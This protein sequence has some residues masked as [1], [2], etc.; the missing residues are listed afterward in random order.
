MVVQRNAKALAQA[1][2]VPNFYHQFV[3]TGEKWESEK[4]MCIAMDTATKQLLQ[5]LR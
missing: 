1:L 5:D 3:Y 2:S 4:H